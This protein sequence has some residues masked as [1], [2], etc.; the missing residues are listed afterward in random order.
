MLLPDGTS[1][2]GPTV[3]LFHTGRY[4]EDKRRKGCFFERLIDGPFAS[5]PAREIYKGLQSVQQIH[6][7]LF[8][9]LLLLIERKAAVINNIRSRK[10]L[11]YPF[12]VL[13]R[14]SRDTSAA[15]RHP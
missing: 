4:A 5:E 2:I 11:P 7:A 15:R 1:A 6:A 12:S 14:I 13:I 3:R 10:Q 9:P 8:P